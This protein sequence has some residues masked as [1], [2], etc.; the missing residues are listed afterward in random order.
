MAINPLVPISKTL[1]VVKTTA[2]LTQK[3]LRGISNILSEKNK[4][5]KTISSNIK[6]LKQRRIQDSRRKT[7]QD[8][9]S[10]PTVV[11]SYK[12]PSILAQ[13]SDSTSFT[14]RIMGFLG[15]IAAG[16]TLRNM[17]TWISIGDQLIKRIGE[18]RG[19]ITEFGTSI[20]NFIFDIGG[21]FNAAFLN[22]KQFDFTDN[23]GRLRSSLDELSGTI[24]TMGNQL[25][26][27]LSILTQPFL[28]VPPLGS[29]SEKPSAYDEK[30]EP[31][32]PAG[33]GG[34]VGTKEQRAMLD[35]I[36]FAEGT[37]DQPN[38]GYNTMFTFKQF[39]GYEDHPRKI[40]R[41][42]GYSS[43][44]AGRYQFLSTTWDR[45]ARKL[46]LKDFSP[47]NQDK[48]AI[49]LAREKGIT[50]NILEKEGMSARVSRLLGTQWAA[51][52]GS[53]LGQGTKSLSS[54]QKA[55]QISLGKQTTTLN[56]PVAKP[57]PTTPGKIPTSVI[58]EIN[59]SG[60]KGGTST[61]GRSGGRG[62]YLS[63]GGAHKGIDIGTSG[64]KG[65][66]V[67]FAQSGKVTYAGWN[68]GGYGYLVIIRSGNLE[69]FFAHL[70]K[71]S[72]KNGSPYNGETIGEIG[73]TGRSSGIHLHFEV[74][75]DG[76]GAINPEPYLK[77]L[78]IGRQFT[79]I[80]GKPIQPLTPLVGSDST[81]VR[82]DNEELQIDSSSIASFGKLMQSLTTEQR[83]R[84][85]VVIDDRKPSSPPMIFSSGGDDIVSS[86][87]NEF[88]LVNNFMKN[89]LLLDLTY[90]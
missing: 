69:F 58:D 56:P 88:T 55:Y 48:A 29:R 15:F 32:T 8:A 6:I 83:G 60:P 16:W 74:R 76:G 53:N 79:A 46:G 25:E 37:R 18:T 2:G 44:A 13:K 38:K 65:Y 81:T 57:K 66:Y 1:G 40:N 59:V 26:E 47:E 19:V 7:I 89:K 36:A 23:S 78:S 82:V 24:A 90:L 71:I 33:P 86:G 11:T 43:D 84:K 73:N 17:P 9:I 67:S 12:G 21:I 22:I 85:V 4:D 45:L 5:R 70:A 52:S 14:S 39:S 63:R 68:D 61:V 87:A 3:T 20:Q 51:M 31:P 27:A 80:D 62:E 35:A 28:D 42:G 77:F 64:Q 54:I 75:I 72:V 50:Q 30:P 49:E 34:S 41:G 10:A